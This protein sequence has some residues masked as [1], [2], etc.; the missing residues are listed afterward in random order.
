MTSL[1]RRN[2]LLSTLGLAGSLSF[3]SGHGLSSTGAQNVA[4]ALRPE[5]VRR[6]PGPDTL[7]LTWQQDPTTTITIQWVGPETS[8]PTTIEYATLETPIWQIARTSSTPFT[9]TNLKV[10]RC[11]ITQLKP[12]T[13]YQF[14]LGNPDD[15]FRF[16]TMPAKATNSIQFVSGG[17][18]GVNLHAIRSNIL[19]ANQEPY[20]ALIAGDLAYD[21][22]KS[23]EVFLQFLRNYHEHMVDPVGRSIP[24]IACLGNHEVNGGYNKT[25]AES[26]QFLSLFDGFY[27][28]RT[29]GVF[30][31]GNYLSL[32]LLDT[33]HIAP[34]GGE[35]TDWL[36]RTLAERQDRP[37]LIVANHVPAY[38]SYRPP[39]G[40]NGGAG[41]GDEQRKNWCPLFERYNVDVVLEHHDHT[42]KRT[43]PLIN[44]MKDKQGIV[45]L[46][47]GSWGK[48]RI[49]KQPE[50]RPY[51]AAVSPAYH[52]TL[53]RLEGDHRFHVALEE[54]GRIADVCAT[55]SK[56]PAL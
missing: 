29:Y 14:H 32:V 55:Y 46:G 15:R 35:Q 56:R 49:P 36:A 23:P 2:F 53:H 9:N 42:F 45:Y 48:L 11:Q 40:V 47:D 19:A 10:H 27:A 4:D 16:R 13:E 44:G 24:L 39:E 22:G 7:I 25:R 5:N 52:V 26:P 21:N 33:G 38:P 17:D 18:S 6:N 8:Q 37:H 54:S 34:I 41:T 43:Y 30:D 50:S 31:I 20:F 51:L 12:D 3:A 1:G 28:E